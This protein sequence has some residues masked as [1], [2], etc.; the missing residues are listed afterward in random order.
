LTSSRSYSLQRQTSHQRAAGSSIDAL[1][2]CSES[3][4]Q[5]YTTLQGVLRRLS[6]FCSAIKPIKPHFS[7]TQVLF[8]PFPI[9]EPSITESPLSGHESST[10]CQYFPPALF[11]RSVSGTAGSPRILYTSLLV[12]TPLGSSQP[13]LLPSPAVL[14]LLFNLFSSKPQYLQLCSSSSTKQIHLNSKHL[15]STVLRP[16]R[17]PRRV[18]F[19]VRAGRAVPGIVYVSISACVSPDFV[20]SRLRSLESRVKSSID[21][22]ALYIKVD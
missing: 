22:S 2:P 17:L 20:P 7:V 21:E 5:S 10:R 9:P 19:G 11:P 8:L 12:L 1:A 15:A 4:Q 14:V 3:R 16:H 13:Y 6:S 18:S